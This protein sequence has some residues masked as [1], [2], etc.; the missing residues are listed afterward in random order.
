[1]LPVKT[2]KTLTGDFLNKGLNK[3][4][5][6]H[7]AHTLRPTVELESLSMTISCVSDETSGWNEIFERLIASTATDRQELCAEKLI[8]H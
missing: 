4:P 8:K 3:T 7:L 6:S 1:M 2:R 5:L